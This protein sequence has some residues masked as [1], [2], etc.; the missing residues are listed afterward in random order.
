[1][2]GLGLRR[3]SD[4][5]E[6]VSLLEVAKQRLPLYTILLE[7]VVALGLVVSLV[8]TIRLGG[9]ACLQSIEHFVGTLAE[10]LNS[11]VSGALLMCGAVEGVVVGLAELRRKQ[12]V[13]QARVEALEE[14]IQQ[15]IEIERERLR[16][17]GIEVPLGTEQATE[18]N[19]D[20]RRS[21]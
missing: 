20:D 11:Y 17:A 6:L 12:S 10:Y 14:G 7:A 15:G 3:G 5:G 8:S 21:R 13:K 19:P 2:M 18:Q 16:R 4:G 9:C 1:M